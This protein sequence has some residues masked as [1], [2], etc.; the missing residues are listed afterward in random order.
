MSIGIRH[1]SGR[2]F[3]QARDLMPGRSLFRQAI[4]RSCIL[5]I[6]RISTAIRLAGSF[7]AAEAS[8][9]NIGAGIG[10]EWELCYCISSS[11]RCR[12]RLWKNPSIF[13]NHC[14]TGR[15]E[16]TVANNSSNS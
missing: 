2:N 6:Q 5:N 13:F 9:V 3:G 8:D 12:K 4:L 16:S 7:K 15:S 10:S 14:K 11:W 1:E